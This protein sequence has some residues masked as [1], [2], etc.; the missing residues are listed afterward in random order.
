MARVKI[1]APTI[2]IRIRP[3]DPVAAKMLA[4]ISMATVR[5]TPVVQ[6]GSRPA[7]SLPGPRVATAVLISWLP[8][9]LCDG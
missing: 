3:S 9:T 6:D 1:S 5:V 8:R 7:V 4:A 2:R